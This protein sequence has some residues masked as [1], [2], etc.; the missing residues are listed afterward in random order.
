MAKEKEEAEQAQQEVAPKPKKKKLIIIAVVVVLLIIIGGTL[1][2]FLSASE[3]DEE[4]LEV[5]E[6]EEGEEAAV[7]GESKAVLPLETFIVNLQIKGSFL[8]TTIQLEF[9][10]PEVPKTAEADVPKI[11]D[12]II[13]IMSS[14]SSSEILSAEGKETLREELKQ[15]INKTL[16]SE[17]ISQIYF[18]EFIIQ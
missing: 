14:K 4:S 3:E 6:E 12:V 8:K 17:D 13:K 10:E 7:E 9:N 15:G 16:G 2:Y 1:A 18:T 11:R 5:T